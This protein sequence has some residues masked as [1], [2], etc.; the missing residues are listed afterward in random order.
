MS[1][2]QHPIHEENLEERLEGIVTFVRKLLEEKTNANN[3]ERQC[4]ENSLEDE[5]ISAI[6]EAVNFHCGKNVPAN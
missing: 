5:A 3:Q 1:E 2:S 6:A 4:E